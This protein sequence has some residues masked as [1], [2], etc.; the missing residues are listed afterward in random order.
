LTEGEAQEREILD[1][2]IKLWNHKMPEISSLF[3][4]SVTPILI[5]ENVYKITQHMPEF[6]VRNN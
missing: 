5:G 1:M 4:V 2:E 3:D 6:L